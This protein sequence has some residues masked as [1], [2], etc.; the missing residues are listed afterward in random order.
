MQQL[1]LPS[2]ASCTGG[3]LC[4][5][6]W[7][8]WRQA[9]VAAHGVRRT[10]R[11]WSCGHSTMLGTDFPLIL[12]R[13]R[14]DP[15]LVPGWSMPACLLCSAWRHSGTSSAGP[16]GVDNSHNRPGGFGACD[17]GPG[18][19]WFWKLG[20][21]SQV[22]GGTLAVLPGAGPACGC[23]R[24]PRRYLEKSL[25]RP[26]PDHRTSPIGH[27]RSWPFT[28]SDT[29]RFRRVHRSPSGLYV[30]AHSRTQVRQWA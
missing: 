27:N 4:R 1:W 20:R 11:A 30:V 25:E 15:A 6:R 24:S 28:S 12:A 21:Q 29:L 19:G 18:I 5:T 13:P 23:V 3:D 26:I 10:G 9:F 8:K 17:C 2:G 7:C 14:S 22:D 16:A